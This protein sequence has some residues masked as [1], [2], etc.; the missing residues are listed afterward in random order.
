MAQPELESF[1]RRAVLIKAETT[2]GVDANPLPAADG[3]QFFDGNATTEFDKIERAEDRPYFGGHPFGTA[4]HRAT[5]EGQ[6]ELYPPASP[7]Q[8]AN[9]NAYCERVLLPAGMTVVKDAGQ[10]ITRYNPISAGIPSVTAYWYHV[11]RLI[12]V[13]GARANISQLGIEIGQRFTGQ[14]SIMGEYAEVATQQ[15]PAVTL[16]TRVP[17][18]SSKRNSECILGTIDRGGTAASVGTPLSNLHTWAKSLKIDF[19][20]QLG[21][22]E[23]TEKG[24]SGITDRTPTFTLRLAATDITDDF[25]PWFIRKEGI[26][27]T[28]AYRLYDSDSKTGL[29]SEL[30]VR[31]QI[32][33]INEVDIEGDDGFEISG[34]C[35]P[36]SA[37]NDE[38][39]IGFGEA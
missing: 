27:M 10:K 19:G 39:Y 12:R 28:A 36:S 32:E 26:I 6:F 23:Y 33:S 29:F 21:Y 7:G 22:R 34:S 25:D 14:A 38:F 31:C 8:A 4:N 30:G 13:L 16:P 35:I 3:F 11:R 2:E 1:R 9:S 37:G 5:I 15:I 20:N 24:V 17:V 18:I